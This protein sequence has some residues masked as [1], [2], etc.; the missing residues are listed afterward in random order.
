MKHVFEHLWTD[1][2]HWVICHDGERKLRRFLERHKLPTTRRV[3]YKRLIKNQVMCRFL[4]DAIYV[5]DQVTHGMRLTTWSEVFYRA[6][7]KGKFSCPPR[8]HMKPTKRKESRPSQLDRKLA[9][10]TPVSP[11]HE[12]ARADYGASGA[13]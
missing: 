6:Y 5:F 4:G 9:L 3:I 12:P 8:P 11:V 2:Q 1:G 13:W 7:P 10:D